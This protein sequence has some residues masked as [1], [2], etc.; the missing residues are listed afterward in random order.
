[1]LSNRVAASGKTEAERA[2]AQAT[3]GLPV[4]S[5]MGGVLVIAPDLRVLVYDPE[6][7]ASKEA[8]AHWR[9]VA[10]VRAAEKFPE[11]R[12]LMPQRPSDAEDC[13]ACQGKGTVLKFQV[14]CGKCG[15]TG[16]VD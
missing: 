14:T 13:K 1:M 6:V 2:A 3:G 10:L 7:L 11:L 8:D 9:R 16:W 12:S 4:Y 15:G 5:D